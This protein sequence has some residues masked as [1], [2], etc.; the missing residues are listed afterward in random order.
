MTGHDGYWRPAGWNDLLAASYRYETSQLTMTDCLP[1]RIAA[2]VAA[3][4]NLAAAAGQL[5]QSFQAVYSF[6]SEIT[7]LEAINTP[8]GLT[9]D[10]LPHMQPGWIVLSHN[11]SRHD[12]LVKVGIRRRIDTTDRDSN[13]AVKATEIAE[14]CNLLYEILRLF[15]AGRKLTNF[16][17]TTWN[18]KTKPAIQLYDEQQLKQGLYV[19]WIHL[20]FIAHE[21]L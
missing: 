19:G 18:P 4:I 8:S 21:L 16:P 5:S 9:V 14:Y 12:V 17:E 6:G 20:P 10:V 1:I 13:G 2:A 15:A 7:A 11:S 3:E